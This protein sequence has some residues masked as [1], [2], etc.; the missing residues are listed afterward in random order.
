[1]TLY[2]PP[3]RTQIVHT[4]AGCL[5][6]LSSIW[7]LWTGYLG[8]NGGFNA[9]RSEGNAICTDGIPTPKWPIGHRFEL[10]KHFFEYLKVSTLPGD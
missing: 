2:Y 9:F 3:N 10:G 7:V 4:R 8:G 1:M 5:S 6:N